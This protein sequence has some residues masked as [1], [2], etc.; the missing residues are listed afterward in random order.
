[1]NKLL[2]PL[3]ILSVVILTSCNKE[4]RQKERLDGKWIYTK[5]QLQEKVFSRK[6]ILDTYRYLDVFFT[7]DGNVT[8]I[9]VKDSLVFKGT[10][11]LDEETEVNY[12]DPEGNA[13]PVRKS[14]MLLSYI[15]TT[16]KRQYEELWDIVRLGKN[17][18][19][20]ETEIDGKTAYFTLK[21]QLD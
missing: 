11:A 20:Y 8:I 21:R 4:E 1:M 12:I 17:K 15:D 3:I 16:T 7:N 10:Y 2:F 14:Q 18:F 13:I 6:D 19:K 5:A 9:D